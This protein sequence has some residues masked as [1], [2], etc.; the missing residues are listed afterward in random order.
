MKIEQIINEITL[1]LERLKYDGCHSDYDSWG[2]Y[3]VFRFYLDKKNIFGRKKYIKI[4]AWDEPSGYETGEA[5][6]I[7]IEIP[8]WNIFK[9]NDSIDVL[10]SKLGEVLQKIYIK[11]LDDEDNKVCEELR[12]MLDEIKPSKRSKK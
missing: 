12:D 11:A 7:R 6:D 10:S 9:Y 3:Y 8:N 4:I 5:A 2:S 1:N